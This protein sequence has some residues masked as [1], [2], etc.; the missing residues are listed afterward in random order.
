MFSENSMN[1]LFFSL[2]MH[3]EQLSN[4][5]KNRLSSAWTE[6]FNLSY[7]L[8]FQSYIIDKPHELHLLCYVISKNK[9]KFFFNFVCFW[10]HVFIFLNTL[11]LKNIKKYW[12]L[13]RKHQKKKRRGG[14]YEITFFPRFSTVFF[15]YFF[16]Y[17]LWRKKRIN[18]IKDLCL[19]S[20][21]PDTHSNPS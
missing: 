18:L 9:K 10:G 4:Y 16:C 19:Y 8:Y 7:I 1:A 14:W 11:K 3:W 15:F 12:K 2:R 17:F 21:L 20:S 6:R 13:K 5:T